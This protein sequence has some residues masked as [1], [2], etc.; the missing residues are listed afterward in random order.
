MVL[1]TDDEPSIIAWAAAV[2]R[3]WA[4]EDTEQWQQPVLRQSP[5]GSHASKG[6]ADN[7][8]RAVTGL[9]RTWR[10]AVESRCGCKLL[11][12]S[13]LVPWM[14]RHVAYLLSRVAVKAT[15]GRLTSA[16]KAGGRTLD[17]EL[18]T[19]PFRSPVLEFAE[20]VNGSQ[21][22]RGARQVQGRAA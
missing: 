20:A 10:A 3:E 17:E 6:H 19:A 21:V 13:P 8:V 12:S 9:T 14:V 22:R 4:K 7:M 1:E 15:A 2:Q 5:R 11:A 16:V 18:H